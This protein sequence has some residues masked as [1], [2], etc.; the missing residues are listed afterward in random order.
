MTYEANNAAE[1]L[2]SYITHRPLGLPFKV[3]EALSIAA[4]TVLQSP[5]LD[6]CEHL[7]EI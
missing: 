6:T 3:L 1:S 4:R 2:F 5:K 7:E